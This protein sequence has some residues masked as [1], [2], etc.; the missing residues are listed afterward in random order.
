[1]G[2]KVSVRDSSITTEEPRQNDGGSWW[3]FRLRTLLI[4][5]AVFSILF[6]GIA[7]VLEPFSH[8]Q[9]F[10]LSDS[11]RIE[12]LVDRSWEVAQAAYYQVY[13]QGKLVVPRTYLGNIEQGKEYVLIT[14]RDPDLVGV[15]ITGLEGDPVI[16]HDFATGAS[17]P[18]T[19]EGPFAVDSSNLLLAWIALTSEAENA[20]EPVSTDGAKP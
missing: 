7:L 10:E 20:S 2:T 13:D 4:V 8:F 12:I 18:Y 3:Q 5:V 14:T 17:W 19:D 15:S 9:T 6:A 16:I 11:R 1:M